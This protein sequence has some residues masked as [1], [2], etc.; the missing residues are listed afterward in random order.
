MKKQA[1][2]CLVLAAEP[3][4]LLLDEPLDGLDPLI[5]KYVLKQMLDL[6]AEKEMTVL[7]SSHNLREL[8]GICDTVG[9]LADGKMLLERELEDLRNDFCKVQVAFDPETREA[10]Q[11][12]ARPDPYA[13]L[14][15]LWKESRGNVDLLL[16]KG[17]RAAVEEELKAA[18]PVILDP[19]PLT[20][21][22]VF[23]FE[24]G[25]DDREISS[26]IF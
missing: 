18:G 3:D 15:I 20:L 26:L 9:I 24:L 23:I 5:R 1:A 14:N 11:S 19:L 2:F 25:G 13:A 16:V 7:V 6:V 4:V 21:E 10:I 12:G 17:G 22:E 8:E